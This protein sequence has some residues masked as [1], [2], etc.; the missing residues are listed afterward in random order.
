M[1]TYPPLKT[2]GLKLF[3]IVVS[4][5]NRIFAQKDWKGLTIE[6]GLVTPPQ[7]IEGLKL[8][9]IAVSCPNRMGVWV[10]WWVVWRN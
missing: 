7:K 6:G 4:C 2:V 5:P 1:V 3:K 9:K 10:D 8:F